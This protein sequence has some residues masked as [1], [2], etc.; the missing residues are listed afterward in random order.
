MKINV[1]ALILINIIK[2]LK[3][4]YNSIKSTS[5]TAPP[6]SSPPAS[7]L[8][9]IH[10][11]SAY[12]PSPSTLS[13][14]AQDSHLSDQCSTKDLSWNELFRGLEPI[15]C[16]FSSLGHEPKSCLWNHQ[17]LDGYLCWPTVC[18]SKDLFSRNWMDAMCSKAR[19][20]SLPETIHRILNCI[21]AYCSR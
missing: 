5:T 9:S 10:C 7:L 6:L 11:S 19:A 14:P 4:I 8:G 3:Y 2:D 13:L 12:S 17:Q 1:K 18:S 20:E 15:E 16:S 21:S